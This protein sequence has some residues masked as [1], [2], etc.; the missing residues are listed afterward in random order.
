VGDETQVLDTRSERV[1]EGRRLVAQVF[2]PDGGKL[3]TADLSC[4]AW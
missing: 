3:T 1:A 2:V 4:L